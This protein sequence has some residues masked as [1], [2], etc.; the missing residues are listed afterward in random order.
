[1][2]DEHPQQLML[3]GIER[4]LG[5][6]VRHQ[7]RGHAIGIQVSRLAGR[8][9]DAGMTGKRLRQQVARHLV[10]KA[11][12]PAPLLRR[13][14]AVGRDHAHAIGRHRMCLFAHAYQPVD[15]HFQQR[16]QL[17]QQLPRETL[18]ITQAGQ[19]VAH[20]HDVLQTA[21]GPRQRMDF[22]PGA[23]R[24]GDDALQT[25]AV[26]I[27]LQPVIADVQLLQDL[28]H[29][30]HARLAGDQDDAH[31]GIAQLLA[32]R[33]H[34]LQAGVVAFH[35][36]VEQDG[37]NIGAGG[38][39][40]ARFAGR[41]SGQ[42]VQ[43]AVVETKIGQ[44]HA[45]RLL[46][47]WVV[48]H[49]QYGKHGTV[50]RLIVVSRLSAEL[51]H[52]VVARP[53]PHRSCTLPPRHCCVDRHVPCQPSAT[54]PCGRTALPAPVF[55]GIGQAP[56][57]CRVGLGPP[58][59]SQ[60]G[61]RSPAHGFHGHPTSPG[62]PSA[63]QAPHPHRR[64]SCGCQACPARIAPRQSLVTRLISARLV[65]PCA[66]LSRADWRKSLMPIFCAASAISIA[67][68]PL[69]TIAAISSVI[70]IT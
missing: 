54:T 29:R 61:A 47:R 2:G 13:E 3:L 34:Q 39:H 37:R 5:G 21:L 49:A 52:P 33:P 31:F 36:H 64:H 20:L 7:R 56:I 60:L 16:G 18:L 35:H 15:R 8:H 43:R 6:Q 50:G 41:G 62:N 26:Q 9:A 10:V 48:V 51:E 45:Q 17:L 40:R 11:G 1:M 70:G 14:D 69:S 42:Q 38:Q 53:R 59:P 25:L 12:Q 27:G 65:T 68:P 44:R 23:Q 58:G 24:T 67:L 19:A 32:H 57:D 22:A 55:Q 28:A 63:E 30:R 66:A 46:E 4:T